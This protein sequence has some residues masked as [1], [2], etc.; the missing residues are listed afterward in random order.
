MRVLVW[1]PLVSPGG[2]LRLLLRLVPALARQ[3]GVALVRLAVPE[4]TLASGL[5]TLPPTPGVELWPI[6]ARRPV[7]TTRDWLQTEG[8][9]LGVKGTGI[10]KRVLRRRFVPG[11]RDWETERLDAAAAGCDVIYVFW[12][13][14]QR[15]PVTDRPLVCTVQD[16][17]ML[18]FPEIEGPQ[19]TRTEWADTAAWLQRSRR[20]VVSSE[21]TRAK[22]AQLFGPPATEPVVIHHAISPAVPASDPGVQGHPGL[23]PRYV[24][25]PA[26][27]TVHKNH[28][29]L[30]VAWARFARRR[31]LPLVL[32]GNGTE[33]IEARAPDWGPHWQHARLAAVAA[34]HGLRAGV[35]FHALGYVD[36]AAVTAIVRGAA[37][38]VMASLSEGG[39]SYPVEEALD[40]GVPV[41]CSD[42]P[43]MREHLARRSARVGWFDPESPDAIVR[44]LDA[45]LDDYDAA[46]ASAVRGM[47]DPRPSW[48]DVAAEYAAVLRDA[49]TPAASSSRASASQAPASR[50]PTPSA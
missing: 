48:D 23:P 41:L 7:R 22:L 32:F 14:K 26:N 5:V 46:R 16:V 8:R 35:D 3:P 40:L 11:A 39:G 9:I 12:P 33:V 4:E 25:Y 29:T 34:R 21:A 6:L 27:I 19:A 13:H 2:G 10:L 47:H 50:V 49:C 44:A 45:L 18:E 37:A 43:V 1:C 42:I 15:V 17:T 30:L 20:V 38:L 28:Y 24:V 31:E 36:D